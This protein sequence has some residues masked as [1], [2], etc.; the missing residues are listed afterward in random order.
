MPSLESGTEPI[1]LNAR[2]CSKTRRNCNE[3]TH[4]F[5]MGKLT[6]VNEIRQAW[7][8]LFAVLGAYPPPRGVRHEGRWIA[9][10][11]HLITKLSSISIAPRRNSVG[12]TGGMLRRMS[13]LTWRKGKSSA[14]SSANDVCLP[15]RLQRQRR[16]D[17]MC[18]V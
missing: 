9:A 8:S 15:P 18:N 12:K 17:S 3:P 6:P 16:R 13:V 7:V 5:L 14:A 10:D 11:V 1:K 2:H 4:H